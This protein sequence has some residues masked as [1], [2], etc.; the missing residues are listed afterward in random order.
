[1]WRFAVVLICL[2]GVTAGAGELEDDFESAAG[3]T[4]TV[5]LGTGGRVAAT[6]EPRL[7]GSP[8]P[9]GEWVYKQAADGNT[10]G[11]HLALTGGPAQDMTVEAWVFCEGNDGAT[12][13]G[14][15][16]AIVARASLLGNHHMI[17]LAWDPDHQE[18]GDTGDGWV[19][20]QA[21]NG[22]TWDYLGIDFS[23]F[24][25]A[26]PGYILNGTAW[27]S[28]WHRFKL[29]VEGNS[30]AAY[31]DDMDTPV[32]EGTLTISLRDGGAGFYT[33]TSGD[34]AGYYDDFAATIVPLPEKDYDIILRGGTVYRDGLSDPIVADVAIKGDRI[35]I[36]GDV[37]VATSHRE[38]DAAGQ[39]VVPGFIDTHTHADSAAA[40]A[41]YLRQG[42]TTMV[43]GNCG[44]SLAIS[45]LATSYNNMAGQLGANYVGLIGHNRLR[46]EVGFTGTTPTPTQMQNMKN[47]IATGMAAGAFGMSTG[48]I[49]YSGFNSETEEIIELATEVAAHG[50][51][52]ATHM[53]SEG[54]AVLAAVE[55][56][57]RIGRESGCRVQISHAKCSGTAA[58]G[59]VDEYL[60]LVDAAI[61]DGLV[62]RLD[63]YPYP[64]SQTTINVLFPQWAQNNWTDAVQ[65]RREELEED[66]RTGL[67]G[68]G[69]AGA[70]YMISGPFPRRF[71]DEVAQSLGKDPE[72]VL[73]DDI[74]LGG[75][76]AVYHTMREEDVQE[77]MVHEH[78]MVGSDGPT[79][80]HPRGAGTYPRFWGHY[81][82]ELGMF[83]HKESVRK[84]STMAAEQFR[85]LEQR[86]GRIAPGWFADVTVLNPDTVIDRATFESPTLTPLGI[87]YVIVNGQLAINNGS[88]TGVRAGRVLRLQDSTASGEETWAVY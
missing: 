24:G 41:E 4:W 39:L 81:G 55:E 34:Y 44:S 64:A 65:N 16:Q 61:A 72:D 42:V 66:I 28:G 82:R 5:G 48:L 27:P 36:V 3:L 68:R 57:I 70:V 78:V 22:S 33:Y 49:Y 73:I 67:A 25:A 20:L 31:V 12:K 80:G 60:A 40:R 87:P 21:Y 76:S 62:V 88:Y 51:L 50:G 63:Q 15:Y 53:R 1:M 2:L 35:A 9:S 11:V 69:G 29:V 86:R 45:T 77:F 54:G 84:T 74:G 38:I 47:R 23:Q 6:G 8:P 59:L 75:A 58:W 52:Y 37:G 14:G 46:A 83:D 26:T 56:A 85:L 10:A 71:L 7:A 32:V 18:T 30:V 17:R 43:A 19:K 13:R 79:G